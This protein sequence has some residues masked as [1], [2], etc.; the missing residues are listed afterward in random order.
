M[1][2]ILF[3]CDGDNFSNGAFEFIKTM[4]AND[5]ISVTGIFFT[6][7]D[8][9]QL[10]SVSY[11][12]A[13]EPYFKMKAD[14]RKQVLHSEDLFK[15]KC[16]SNGI[17]FHIHD[18]REEWSSDLLVKETRF[19]DLAVMSEELFCANV[20][21]GQPNVFMKLGLRNAECP[22]MLIPE[23]FKPF[24]RI[25]VAYNGKKESM[26]ALKQFCYLFPKLTEL[27][28]EFV[29]AKD[30]KSEDVPDAEWLKEYARLHFGNLNVAKLHFDGGKF[31]S[32]WLEDKKDI[33]LLTGSFSRSALSTAVH[34]SFI[35]QIIHEHAVP[36]FIAH[37]V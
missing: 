29:Y 19:A 16:Q 36:I 21:A 14:E 25:V 32:T 33:L 18:K 5:P 37:H 34:R 17:K 6:P 20:F 8:F 31:F 4:H 28:T 30:E 22:V 23:D 7:I 27:P 9:E 12:P 1:K 15:T 3:V 2:K 11:V 35:E 10:L 26:F 24:R 13:A